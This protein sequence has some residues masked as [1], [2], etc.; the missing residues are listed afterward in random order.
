MSLKTRGILVV[1]VG[2]VIGLG[3]S[4]GGDR[5]VDRTPSLPADMT[6]EQARLI[7][8]VMEHVKHDYVDLVDDR[9]LIESAV[10]GM[11][12]DRKSVV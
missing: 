4:V 3:L 8:E 12:A 5:L 7:S 9:V 11:V 6:W 1:V 2:T 10:R